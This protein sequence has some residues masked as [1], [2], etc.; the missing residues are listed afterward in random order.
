ML[1][2]LLTL[3]IFGFV[4]FGGVLLGFCWGLYVPV[5]WGSL[6][7]FLSFLVL[8]VFFV[9]VLILDFGFGFVLSAAIVAVTVIAIV[10]PVA[11]V[12][13]FISEI[14]KEEKSIKLRVSLRGSDDL[15]VGRGGKSVI[16][17]CCMKNVNKNKAKD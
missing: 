12:E 3:G 2:L 1:L 6:L 16:R 11:V 10:V 5:L 8:V 4:F 9:F 13:L 14:K 15:G 7:D 17:I